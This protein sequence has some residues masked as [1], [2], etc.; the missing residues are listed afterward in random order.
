MTMTTPIAT[1][2]PQKTHYSA[3]EAA[4]ALGVSVEQLHV[5]IRTH[6]AVEDGEMS[7]VVQTQFQAS[8]LLLLRFLTQK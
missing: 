3:E 7:N 1:T 6:L 5:L 2:K 8:D 4:A